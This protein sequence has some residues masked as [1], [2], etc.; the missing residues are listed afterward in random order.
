[1]TNR[2]MET[3]TKLLLFAMLSVLVMTSSCE[4]QEERKAKQAI[5]ETAEDIAGKLKYY[6]NSSKK[7]IK[8]MLR[9]FVETLK[10]LEQ[11]YK[12]N[13]EFKDV[14]VCGPN[15]AKGKADKFLDKLFNPMPASL[16]EWY[17]KKLIKILFK[18]LGCSSSS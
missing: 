18:K 6:L 16:Y 10:K 14:Q 7:D 12:G 13:K 17:I 11:N 4:T 1:V 8:D 5:A 3:Q 15:G 9:D 2:K